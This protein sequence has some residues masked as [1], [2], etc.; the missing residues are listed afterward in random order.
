MLSIS[1]SFITAQTYTAF[2]ATQFY[3][4][5][6]NVSHN[7]PVY[8]STQGLYYYLLS[9]TRLIW[10]RLYFFETVSL[11]SMTNEVRQGNIDQ[12]WI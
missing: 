4:D 8:Y 1:I 12:F 3:S 7:Y 10:I 5:F 6:E 2:S 11:S 9:D